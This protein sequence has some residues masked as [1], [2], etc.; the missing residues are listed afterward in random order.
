M[1]IDSR[2]SCCPL[3]IAHPCEKRYFMKTLC[4]HLIDLIQWKWQWISQPLS[5]T[6]AQIIRWCVHILY[7]LIFMCFLRRKILENVSQD[8]HLSILAHVLFEMKYYGTNHKRNMG[9]LSENMERHGPLCERSK[10]LW[11]HIMCKIAL[12][13]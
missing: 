7:S 8:L 3:D 5:L 6:L 11:L 2:L 9:T 1:E 12:V 10:C 4:S 13:K